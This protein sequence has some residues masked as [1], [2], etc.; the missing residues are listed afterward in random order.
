MFIQKE[1]K[2]WCDRQI[3]SETWC[4]DEVTNGVNVKTRDEKSLYEGP[5][6]AAWQIAGSGVSAPVS[7]YSLVEK[8]DWCDSGIKGTNWCAQ[9]EAKDLN[10]R[11]KHQQGLLFAQKEQKD[12]CDRQIHS[13]KWCDGE[14]TNGINVK[15]LDDKSLFEG[16]TKA[17]WQIAGSG[18]AAPVPPFS[19]AEKKDWCESGIKGTNWCA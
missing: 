3:H 9:E 7:P 12:W 11:S 4:D 1:Q 18:V 6:K 8:K 13:D 5:T 14:V 15:T 10:E 17:A 2:G 16:P 19:L